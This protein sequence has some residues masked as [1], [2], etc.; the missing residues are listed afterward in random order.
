MREARL[1][2]SNI[3]ECDDVRVDSEEVWQVVEQNLPDLKPNVTV[4]L[5]ALNPS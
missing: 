5:Q 2:L 4:I 1:L 3:L